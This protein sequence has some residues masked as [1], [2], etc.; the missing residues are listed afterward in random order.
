M[1]DQNE[2]NMDV[3]IL[4]LVMLLISVHTWNENVFHSRKK[5][6]YDL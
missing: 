3:L 5:T 6:G 2:E 4:E 1:L